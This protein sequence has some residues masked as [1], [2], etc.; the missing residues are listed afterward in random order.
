MKIHNLLDI[1]SISELRAWLIQNHKTEK[2]YR[3]VVK[4][5]KPTNDNTFG[6]LML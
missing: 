2:E 1:E 4:R 3:V 6:I 5:I